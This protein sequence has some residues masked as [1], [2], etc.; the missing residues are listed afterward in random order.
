MHRSPHAQEGLR[1]P[2]NA[3]VLLWPCVNATWPASNLTVTVCPYHARWCHNTSAEQPV[4]RTQSTA[5]YLHCQIPAC[6]LAGSY[7]G[8]LIRSGTKRACSNSTHMAHLNFCPTASASPCRGCPLTIEDFLYRGGD[9]IVIVGRRNMIC[10]AFQPL[11][12]IA[13][14]NCNLRKAHT[15]LTS[16]IGSRSSHASYL[17]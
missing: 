15:L 16:Q 2:S 13:H 14:R 5:C 4:C 11:A 8:M 7:V 3:A 17:T 10:Q 6:L 12:G 9:S 1:T